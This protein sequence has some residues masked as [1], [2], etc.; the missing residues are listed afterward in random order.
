MENT[1]IGTKS[2]FHPPLGDLFKKGLNILKWLQR[3]RI[4]RNEKRTTEVSFKETFTADFV[5][6]SYSAPWLI[7]NDAQV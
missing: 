4:V 5:H 6:F 7:M 1:A 2:V 3:C